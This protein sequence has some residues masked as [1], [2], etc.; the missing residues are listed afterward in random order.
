MK[1]RGRENRPSIIYKFL[2]ILKLT[3]DISVQ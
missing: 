2:K 3:I 1:R